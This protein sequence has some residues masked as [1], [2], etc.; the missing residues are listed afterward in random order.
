M[1]RSQTI[2]NWIGHDWMINSK[3][4]TGSQF[5]FGKDEYELI[6]FM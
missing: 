4:A 5:I 2:P 1:S 6:P 3:D